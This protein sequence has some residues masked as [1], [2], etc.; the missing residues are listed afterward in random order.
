MQRFRIYQCTVPGETRAAEPGPKCSA[1]F[2]SG[3]NSWATV[4]ADSHP[5]ADSAGPK[6]VGNIDA[7]RVPGLREKG[8]PEIAQETAVGRHHGAVIVMD[9]KG[10]HDRV[11]DAVQIAL[12]YANKNSADLRDPG[13]EFP[14]RWWL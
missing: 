6:R 13:R 7:A 2:T 1:C 9:F 10:V 5:D 12:S 14:T 11:L 8:H 4:I 3:Q